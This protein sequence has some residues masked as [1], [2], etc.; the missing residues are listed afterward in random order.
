S[1]LL[2]GGLMA[3][4]VGEVILINRAEPD[5]TPPPPAGLAVKLRLTV[6]TIVLFGA[7]AGVHIWLGVWP[8]PI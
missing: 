3:W 5:W 4:A 2:F 6:I 7:V 8:F 1:I